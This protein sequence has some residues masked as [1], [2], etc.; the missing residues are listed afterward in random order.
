MFFPKVNLNNSAYKTFIYEMPKILI[1]YKCILF[2]WKITDGTTEMS[3]R[4][5]N[6]RV[7]NIFHST[8]HVENFHCS[9]KA[10]HLRHFFL[11]KKVICFGDFMNLSCAIFGATVLIFTQYNVLLLTIRLNSNIFPP[12]LHA[13]NV[14]FNTG[15]RDILCMI[16]KK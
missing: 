12:H 10:K 11:V 14:S 16:V 1:I 2:I 6:I 7:V 3:T 8:K 9:N 15:M 13:Q 5:K 4:V